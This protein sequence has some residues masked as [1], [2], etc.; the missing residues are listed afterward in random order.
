MTLN[1]FDISR[2]ESKKIGEIEAEELTLEILE[3]V[4]RKFPIKNLA[5]TERKTY[6]VEDPAKRKKLSPFNDIFIKGAQHIENQL[7]SS[8]GGYVRVA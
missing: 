1:I 4:K 5:V 8:Y 2:H 7:V 6:R 3:E